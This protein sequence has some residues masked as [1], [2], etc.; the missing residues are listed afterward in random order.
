MSTKGKKNPTRTGFQKS[1]WL[2][3]QKSRVG[4]SVPARQKQKDLET[5]Q[6]SHWERP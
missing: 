5:R 3:K 1:M 2:T 4:K 6:A